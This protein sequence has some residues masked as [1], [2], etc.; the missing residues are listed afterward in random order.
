M[1]AI[2]VA[3]GLVLLQGSAHAYCLPS[4]QLM[5]GA[6]PTLPPRGVLFVRGQCM[7]GAVSMKVRD[8]EAHTTV[9]GDYEIIEFDRI[10]GDVELVVARGEISKPVPLNVDANW[11]RPSGAPRLLRV[12]RDTTTM[13]CPHWDDLQFHFDRGAA[14]LELE[15]SDGGVRRARRVGIR[16]TGAGFVAVLAVKESPPP[17][18]VVA[19][20]AIEAD[21]SR[22]TVSPPTLVIP[23]PY[24][25]LH[26]AP[27][28]SANTPTPSRPTDR[29]WIG[30]TIAAAIA[31]V[32]AL[33]ARRFAQSPT[34]T[35]NR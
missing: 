3:A 15:W 30:A 33:A 1:R 27:P 28:P 18:T 32:L 5:D 21:G 34:D 25:L 26:P 20:R 24:R 10:A 23:D 14:G 13:S 7:G 4:V 35:M 22:T 2:A 31:A 6:G 11:R 29:S 12:S 17:G 9:E 16:M 8:G 19:L